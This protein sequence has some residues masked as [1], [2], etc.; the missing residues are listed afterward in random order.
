MMW[1]L[2]TTLIVVLCSTVLFTS[3]I[4]AIEK[5]PQTKVYVYQSPG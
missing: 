1:R 2:I 4:H 3:Q 5:G